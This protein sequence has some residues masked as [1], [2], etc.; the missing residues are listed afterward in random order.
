MNMKLLH[1]KNKS[2]QAYHCNGFD[3][4]I[5]LENRFK[6]ICRSGWER[7]NKVTDTDT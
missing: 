6:Y 1:F 4:I 2:I 7:S 3:T 5:Q